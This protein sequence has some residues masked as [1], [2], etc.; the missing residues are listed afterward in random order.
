MSLSD[1]CERN[2]PDIGL[3]HL[4]DAESGEIML[5][6]TGDANIRQKLGLLYDQKKTEEKHFFRRQ[7]ID[8]VAMQTDQSYV[9]P[10]IGFFRNRDKWKR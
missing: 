1:I 7:N 6:D 4:Q 9:K 10:L 2:L 5:F 8:H 3:V